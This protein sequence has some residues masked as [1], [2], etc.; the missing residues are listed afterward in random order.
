[1]GNPGSRNK[2]ALQIVREFQVIRWICCELRFKGREATQRAIT[3]GLYTRLFFLDEPTALAAGHRPCAEC[4]RPAYKSFVTAWSQAFP[5]KHWSAP[6]IDEVLHRERLGPKP[7]VP[8]QTLPNAAMVEWA[9]APH[10][11]HDGWLFPW[12]PAGY[13]EPIEPPSGQRTLLLTPP[14]IVETISAGYS[15]VSAQLDSPLRKF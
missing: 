6:M 8:L 2:T 13:L 4:R 12:T 14:S 5:G 9:G 3:P 15:S 7:T 1:M 11:A 10:M